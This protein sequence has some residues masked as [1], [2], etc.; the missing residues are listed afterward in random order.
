VRLVERHAELDST[1][2][3][4]AELADAGAPAGSL[5][6]ADR[7]TAGLGRRGHSWHSPEGG[8]Y[9]TM[10][11]RP[12][13]EMKDLPVVTLALG[14]AVAEA[15]G[16]EC[17]LRWPN[18]VMLGGR[19]LVGIL[20]QWHNQAVLAGIGV[21]IAQAEFPEDLSAIAASLGANIDRKAL[22]DK[23]AVA[24]DA[25]VAVLESDG[26]EAILRLFENASSYVRGKRVRV[27]LPGGD[28]HGTT[29]GLTVEGYL[30]L[31]RDDGTEMIVTAG[32]VRPE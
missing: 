26:V 7:Q 22:L 3:R 11:L 8:L 15:L 1:M 21:N 4:A 17:D 23:I 12:R 20:A 9:F 30:K 14:V 5:V 13:V 28:V 32:G 16:V 19:K 6:V 10:V 18:D 2:R 27:E 24:I 25:H 29:A 31:R